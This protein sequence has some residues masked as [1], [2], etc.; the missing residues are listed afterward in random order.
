MRTRRWVTAAVALGTAAALTVAVP[1]AAAAENAPPRPAPAGQKPFTVTLI[2]GDR[3]TVSG[4]RVTFEHGPGRAGIRF[5]SR[6]VDGH[7]HV[8]PSDAMPLLRQGRLDDRLFDVTALREF[9]YT[10]DSDLPLLVKYPKNTKRAGVGARA[11]RVLAASGLL[12]T[13]TSRAERAALWTSMTTG[14]STA[15]TLSAGVERVY[16]DG[17]RDL[18]LDVSVPQIGAPAAWQQ[19]LD[20]TGV[21]VAVIDT[22]IDA[23][24]PDFA[25]KIVASANFTDDESTDDLVGHG[26]HVASIVAGTG[27]KSGGKYRGVAPGAQLAIAKACKSRCSESALLAAMEWAA[28]RASVVNL[29]VGGP[30]SSELDPMEQA[31]NDLTAQYGTLFVAAAGNLGLRP[32]APVDSPASA[33][34]ALAVGAVDDRDDLAPLSNRGPRVGDGAVKPDITAPGVNIV[35]ARAA[36]GRMGEPVDDG[37]TSLNGTSMATP[38]VAGAAAI[39]SQQHA[40]WS[41]GRKK[42]ALMGAAQPNTALDIFQQGAGRVDVGRA[43]RQTVVADLPSVNFGVQAW[44]HSDDT[45]ISKTLTYRNSGTAAVALA[46]TI[47]GGSGMFSVSPATLTVPAGGTA[48]A[49]A[50]ADT[51]VEGT[52]G[53]KTARVVASGSP[54]TRIV[55]PVV[56]N[57]DVERYDVTFSHID[58]TGAPDTDFHFGGLIRLDRQQPTEYITSGG[59]DETISLPKGSYGLSTEFFAGD[60]TSVLVHPKLVVDRSMTVTLDAR[61]AKPVKVTPPRTDARQVLTTVDAVWTT[62]HGQAGTTS[63][64]YAPGDLLAARVG[65]AQQADEFSALVSSAFAKWKND[66]EGFL[67]SPF[68]YNVAYSRSGDFFTGFD[69]KVRTADLA[70]VRAR[71]AQ[72]VDGATGTKEYRPSLGRWN[73]STESVP[74]S[75]PFERTEYVG[76][77]GT[78]D[79]QGEFAQRLDGET[80]STATGPAQRPVAGKVYQQTWNTPVFAPSVAGDPALSG[81]TR[82]DDTIAAYVPLF[83]DGAGHGGD[84]VTDTRRTALYAAGQLVGETDGDFPD[85]PVAAERT[86]YRLEK[87]AT[88]SAPF[89]LSTSVSGVWTFS[90]AS[91]DTVLPVSTVRFSPKHASAG[92]FTI[93]VTVDRAP[94]SAAGSNRTLTAEFSTDDGRTWRT[95]TVSSDRRSIRVTNPTS[96]FVSLRATSTD[97]AGNTATVTVIR[98]YVIS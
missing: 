18:S 92:S 38:H 79:W 73:G 42:A 35:A 26:T 8:V 86:A 3:V 50:V 80:L 46:L 82:R 43:V 66:D 53:Y 61:T 10:G 83:G 49:T 77:D 9:G 74:F 45:P 65:P 58:R 6:I 71:Y 41:P 5:S 15:R 13:T 2:T 12:A 94:G 7:R 28:P 4:D 63:F 93:P 11:G 95:A 56:V 32:T 37:Y 98:A 96:G 60:S 48:T 62:S 20:G 97:T 88:R 34:A 19:G 59:P 39:L 29:S 33:D 76:G 24:H 64:S 87:S 17:Q 69:M 14:P 90:S 91:G 30:D 89:R 72:D 47:E 67:D 85:F 75:L 44:P 78:V 36:N 31:V 23:T 68:S 84:S 22:G 25:G 40:D 70:T 55:T 16:L 57:R 54:D 52:D 21:T 1:S 81:V 27:A 51:R